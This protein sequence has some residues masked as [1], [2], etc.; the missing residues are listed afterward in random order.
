M[1]FGSCTIFGRAGSRRNSAE[2]GE[3]FALGVEPRRARNARLGRNFNRRH[4]RPEAVGFAFA[5]GERQPHSDFGF[6]RNRAQIFLSAA[7]ESS[8]AESLRGGARLRPLSPR[9]D[10]A[11]GK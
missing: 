8:A 3:H 6:A 7:G 9:E 11:A 10:R 4:A 5:I 2:R 1:S